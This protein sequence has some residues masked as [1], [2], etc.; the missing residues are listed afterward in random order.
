M[1]FGLLAVHTHCILCTC[2][3]WQDH[4]FLGTGFAMTQAPAHFPAGL[5]CHKLQEESMSSKSSI[6]DECMRSKQ[7]AKPWMHR[8]ACI[9]ID[10]TQS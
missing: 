9:H 10:H 8:R 3:L 5:N 1:L 7:A 2:S 6:A 4:L